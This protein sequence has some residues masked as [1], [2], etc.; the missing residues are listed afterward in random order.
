MGSL[1]D[2]EQP[3]VTLDQV[4]RRRA[5]THADRVLLSYPANES[6]FVDYT[7]ADLERLTRLAAHQYAEAFAQLDDATRPV[8]PSGTVAMVGVSDLDYYI[9]FLALQRLGLSSMFIS[10]RLAD[11]GFTHLLASTRCA[12]VIASGPS[13][14]TMARLRTSSNLPISLI[15]MLPTTSLTDS[16]KPLPPPPSSSDTTT[17]TPPQ[18]FIIHSGGTTGLPKPVPLLARSWLLQAAAIAG[19]MPRAAALSTLPLFH[20][21]GLAT[22]L[23][24]LVNGARLALLSAARPVTAGAVLGGLDATGAAALVTVPYVLKFLAEAEAEGEGGGGGVFGRLAALEQV[25]AAGSAVPDALGDALVVG[26]GVRLFHLY[27]LTECGALMEPSRER[28]ELWNWVTPLPDAA[29][30]LNFE[31]VAAAAEEEEGEGGETLYHLVVLPGLKA[32]VLSDRPDGSYA[33]KDLFRRHPELPNHWKFAARLDDIVVL[34]NGEKA[35]P[36]PLETAVTKNPLVAAAVV[37]GAGR[38]AL[39][40]VVVASER[41]AGLSEAQIVERIL[42]DLERGNEGV[43]AYARVAPEALVVKGAGTRFPS[44]DKATVIR[45]SFLK[46]FAGEIEEFY[47][48]RERAKEDDADEEDLDPLDDAGVRDLVR[49]TVRGELKLGE[50]G[51]DLTDESDFF[52]L[53]M[54]SLQATNVRSRLLK[55]VSLGGRGLATNVVFDHPTVELL[56]THLLKVR[57]GQENEQQSTQDFAMRLLEKYSTFDS[58]PA[59]R[60]ATPPEKESILLTGATG[61]L[62]IHILSVL[63]PNPSIA[64]IHCLVRASDAPT[65]LSRIH[66]ALRRSHLLTTSSPF[67]SKIS[68]IPCDLSSPRHGLAAIPPATLA[69]ITATTTRVIH[70]AWSVDFNRSLRSF[71][72]ACLAPTHALLQLA[73]A[74]TAAPKP[75]FV[76]VSSIAAAL[77]AGASSSSAASS[78][79]STPSLTSTTTTTTTTSSPPS[80][81]SSSPAGGARI[82]EALYPFSAAADGMGYGQSKWVAEQMCA[83]AAAAATAASPGGGPGGGGLG[84]ETRVLRV[85][86]L[87]GDTAHGVWNPAEAVP[88]TV[89]AALGGSSVGALPVVEGDEELS[90]LPVDVAARAVVELAFAETEAEAGGCRVWHV[91]NEKRVRWNEEFLP[92]LRKAGLAFE[93]VPQRE[94]VGRL[95]RSEQDGERNPPVKLLEFFKKRYGGAAVVGEEEHP[96][97]PVF[98]MTEAGKFA[99]S[100]RGGT[101]VDEALV[102]K[103][104]RFWMEEWTGETG[105]D[106]TKSSSPVE[107]RATCGAIFP[108][109]EFS[110]TFIFII[111]CDTGDDV[112]VE[113]GKTGGGVGDWQAHGRVTT[114]EALSATSTDARAATSLS[115]MLPEELLLTTLS[116]K[117]PCRELQIRQL[118]ALYNPPLPSPS[119]LIVHGLDATGKTSI[120]RGVLETRKLP[121]AIIN[122]RECITGRHLLE[123]TLAACLDAVDETD[124]DTPLDRAPYARCENLSALFVQLQRLLHGTPRFVL[125]FDGVDKQRE[126]PPT[127]L[128]ALARLGEHVRGLSTLLVLSAPPRPR[129]LHAASTPCV[130]F[131]S[132]A[133]DEAVLILARRGPPSTIY[134]VPPSPSKG[135]T[136]DLA[137][138]DDAWVW[139]RFLGVVWEALAKS[140]ARDVVGF[141]ALADKLWDAF[142]A[143]V[144]DGA[145]GTRDFSRLLVHRRAIF[146]SEAALVDRVVVPQESDESGGGGGASKPRATHDLPYFSKYLLCA[147]YLASYNPARQDGIYFMK[148]SEKKRRKRGGGTATSTSGRRAAAQHRKIS[149]HLLTPSAF[150]LDRLLAI[151]RAVLPPQDAPPASADV[152]TAVATLNSLRLLLRSGAAGADPLDGSCKWRVN[153]GWEYVRDLGRSVGL[154]MGE[155]L[156]GV[157]DA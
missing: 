3:C 9:T 75:V 66:T 19:R 117:F 81:A 131:P 55:R 89:R 6:D 27:G 37:F 155:Y 8:G 48:K 41:A 109:F 156:A 78:A 115:T 119:T 108:N 127:L 68:A 84:I 21:F 87:C 104:L 144:R 116:E 152:Y 133:R 77:R 137:A 11:Q 132:Y 79:A 7:G 154:E 70:A 13:Q 124:P 25:V 153:Y 56:A 35:D 61:A 90:W 135:Y 64:T 14:A 45:S 92:A 18:R 134:L 23:R 111:Y 138:E 103:F 121:H 15:P 146:Q 95:E 60:T 49:R 10:P 112:R 1:P 88:T 47:A 74:S 91:E 110:K 28:R 93:A 71:D 20:S 72:A 100:L 34:V 97:H 39:G 80:P 150:P 147:A 59:P 30:F 118:A 83:A 63:L 31:A 22:L 65:A 114:R 136:A 52:A 123:R 107:M 105:E 98:D 122:S 101:V 157:V 46:Q 106:Q 32:K 73:A 85:G 96:A 4:I 141:A 143:P 12:V 151:F 51:A 120:V 24:C 16:P 148:A 26:A 58:Q 42:P 99:P 38:D 44:T 128:P 67:L 86:Q 50:R 33:T 102:E 53:G 40:M 113:E 125:V 82:P 62:G 57:A 145:F 140:A 126:A 94:W 69:H 130:H 5:E 36:G 139:T 142:V 43:P 149:R 29:P 76:F 54:D 2:A 129:L 17:T